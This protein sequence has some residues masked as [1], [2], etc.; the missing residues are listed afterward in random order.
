MVKQ[1]VLVR[2]KKGL[3]I[4]PELYRDS[5]VD[6]VAVANRLYTPSYV[7]FDYALQRLEGLKRGRI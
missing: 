4:F 5:S 7:S 2:L 3:Y 1:G 6:M